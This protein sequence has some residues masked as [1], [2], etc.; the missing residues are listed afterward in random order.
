MKDDNVINGGSKDVNSL[1]NEIY[2]L[3]KENNNLRNALEQKNSEIQFWKNYRNNMNNK[4]TV[5]K[6]GDFINEM[7][8]KQL[9]RTLANYG[10]KIKQLN[11]QYRNTLFR[12]QNEKRNLLNQIQNLRLKNDFAN[13]NNM[14]NMNKLNN[15][16]DYKLYKN[17]NYS[18]LNDIND[19]NDVNDINNNND[20]ENNNM[21]NDLDY[22]I[23]END[24]NIENNINQR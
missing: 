8:I 14:N 18:D 20:L 7:K 24:A 23:E 17:I 16:N 15:L 5:N 12:H 6:R 19:V 21:M 3:R 1:R 9:E 2:I 10:N 4:N 13:N 11:E 22:N